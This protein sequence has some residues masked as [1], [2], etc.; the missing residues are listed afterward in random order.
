MSEQLQ[1]RQ[2]KLVNCYPAT[3]TNMYEKHSKKSKSKV[4]TSVRLFHLSFFFY[5]WTFQFVFV[6]LDFL[7]FRAFRIFV[8]CFSNCPVWKWTPSTFWICRIFRLFERHICFHTL[9]FFD[10]SHFLIQMTAACVETDRPYR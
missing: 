4:L 7:T 5:L 10:F 2:A 3:E 1:S 6:F 9:R 8:F